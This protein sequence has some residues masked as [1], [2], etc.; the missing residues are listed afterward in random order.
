MNYAFPAG[1]NRSD[2]CS[3]LTHILLKGQITVV[4]LA[5]PKPGDVSTEAMGFHTTHWTVVLAASAGEGL[6]R[7]E[8]LASLCESYWYPLYA[9]VRRRGSTSHEAED[10]T[11]E[12]FYRFLE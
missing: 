3:A 11:Q 2:H 1:V 7:G 5:F 12:F 4:S 9:F 10:L 6:K 8:A